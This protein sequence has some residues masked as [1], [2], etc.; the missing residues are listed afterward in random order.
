MANRRCQPLIAVDV[1]NSSAHFGL[2]TDPASRPLPRPTLWMR[3]E[4]TADEFRS[5][6][7]WLPPKSPPWVVASVAHEA[8]Q[9]L[10]DWVEPLRPD[11]A[12]RRLDHGQ[13]PLALAIEHPHTA[14]L[15][16]LAAAVAVNC[17]REPDR[18]A[19]VVDVGTAITVDAVSADGTFLGGAILPGMDL[20]ATAL[21][22]GTSQLPPV[23]TEFTVPPRAIG[24]STEAAIRSGIF[25]GAVGAVRAL[26]AQ[27]V[28]ELG[29]QPLVAVTGGGAELLL[30][31]IDPAG[32]YLHVPHLVLSGIAVAAQ[33]SS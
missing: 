23:D 9:R 6:L 10:I 13:L 19:I 12:Y 16:R 11:V 14:G 32:E 15:D 29:D 26:I 21:V 24:K 7:A 22:A 27:A 2:F 18:P 4:T 33:T 17:L 1:G 3:L 25:W 31:Q 28:Q 30:P 20:S 5:L 8:T